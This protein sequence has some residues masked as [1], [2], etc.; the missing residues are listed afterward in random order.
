M[1]LPFQI[2]LKYVDEVFDLQP[3]ERGD[4]SLISIINDVKNEITGYYVQKGEIWELSVTFAW[5][6]NSHLLP[7][8][9]S[10][11]QPDIPNSRPFAASVLEPDI[12]ISGP[13]ASSGESDGSDVD[14]DCEVNEESD[15]DADSDVSLDDYCGEVDDDMH[16]HCDPIGDN[17]WLLRAKKIVL[18]NLKIDHIA[19]YAKMKKYENAIIAMNPI[20]CV[21]L[22]LTEVPRTKPRKPIC[23]MSDQQKDELKALDN[24]WPYAGKRYITN[25]MSKCFNNW[26]KDERE[27]PIL[28]LLEHLRR[29]VMAR[30]SDKCEELEK[31][32]ESITPYA[33]QTLI[34]NEKKGKEVAS[35]S[36][37]WQII[38]LHCKHVVVVFMYNIVFSH[39]HVHWYYAKEA[40][41]LT[42]SGAINHILEE[43]I[44]PEYYS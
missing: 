40:L 2:Y 38:E 8:L 18:N 14:N 35:I 29:K 7:M 33:R 26:I 25:N 28:T 43:S 36:W 4:Y 27:K 12:P 30:F 24:A 19:A 5:N 31:L 44:W 34:T 37:M 41:K 32:K 3:L 39:D 16:G 15:K 20:A 9:E 42:Y 10:S 11:G 22:S 6:N 17:T 23:F 1:I 13:P 21:K